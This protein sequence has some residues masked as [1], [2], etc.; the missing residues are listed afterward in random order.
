MVGFLL[1]F[2]VL[3][4][5]FRR[6][7]VSVDITELSEPINMSG[8]YIGLPFAAWCLGQHRQFAGFLVWFDVLRPQN[9][10]LGPSPSRLARFQ[11]NIIAFLAN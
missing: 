5:S 4:Y 8:N 9:A 6:L 2:P 7:I 11:Y 1:P 10:R 3:Q